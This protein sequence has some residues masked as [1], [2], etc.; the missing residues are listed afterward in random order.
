MQPS[1][2]F[3]NGKKTGRLRRA[4]RQLT[5]EGLEQRELLAADFGNQS[6]SV[7][8]DA[9][10][11]GRVDGADLNV[12]GLHWHSTSPS[13]RSQGDF[14]GDGKVDATD[15]NILAQNLP[16]TTVPPATLPGDANDDGKVDAADLNVV[17]QNWLS[18]TGDGHVAGDFNGD[19]EVDASDLNMLAQNWQTTTV[20]PATLP[21][22]ANDDGKVDAADLNVV[23]Q[24][25]L[26]STSAGRSAGDL[27]DDGRVDATDL[28]ILALNWQ[29][30]NIPSQ[31]TT[32]DYASR[33]L[34]PVS[35]LKPGDTFVETDGTVHRYVGGGITN[36]L[37][38]WVEIIATQ[39]G[40]A[41]GDRMVDAADL[42]VLALKWQSPTENGSA[43]GDFNGDGRVDASDLGVLALNW[44][45][46]I[47]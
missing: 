15:L 16:T 6:F 32:S 7:L 28:N 39:P 26:S 34:V 17:G 33:G 47:G 45:Q 21:G 24:N 8:G 27:S 13:G 19:G 25:W 31:F 38:Q 29:K 2:A 3:S 41:N 10:N 11:D 35:L 22:D 30:S 5:L 36:S 43:D 23:G 1:C 40:D 20:P 46:G 12:V 42:N 37:D 4:P 14:S 44:Q 18:S 9:N